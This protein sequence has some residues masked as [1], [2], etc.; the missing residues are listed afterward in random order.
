MKVVLFGGSGHGRSVGAVLERLGFE[1]AAVADPSGA[2]P[3][4]GARVHTDDA[5]AIAAA[6]ESELAAVLGVGDNGRRLE[7]AARI[8]GAGA[9][10]PPI[11]AG[12]ATTVSAVLGAGTVVLEHAHVGP[13]S[14]LGDA[15]IVN[16]GAIVE[17]DCRLGN[18]V[19]CAPG[20]VLAGGVEVGDGALVGAGATV[21]P[22]IQIG[23]GAVVAAGA[24]VVGDVAPGAVVAGVPAKERA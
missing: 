19:H 24:A 18:G 3:Y 22:G 2:S 14:V 4:E 21:I 1:V 17:H 12:S 5:E 8:A 13:G 7:L 11:V 20:S 10:L 9:A 15:C 23:A 16:T 6:L